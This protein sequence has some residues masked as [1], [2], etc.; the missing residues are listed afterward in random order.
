MTQNRNKIKQIFLTFPQTVETKDNFRNKVEHM[1]TYGYVVQETH[2]NGG[3]H[4]H[5]ILILKIPKSK[6]NIIKDFK[7]L[8]P[9]S[10]QR[11]KI[12]G[13][14][15]LKGSE[16]YLQKEDKSP[17]QWGIC[18]IVRKTSGQASLVPTQA[19]ISEATRNRLLFEAELQIDKDRKE[20]FA[21]LYEDDEVT[22]AMIE[23]ERNEDH[24]E[25]EIL[26][27]MEEYL[28]GE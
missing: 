9:D 5:A 12:E 18:P 19:M 25:R 21:K 26:K 13:L 23:M 7:V 14:R 10:Y 1:S 27:G 20:F 2:K 8:Y 16:I 17:L 22:Q 4:L 11:I 28:D 6:V 24:I 15:N 3:K